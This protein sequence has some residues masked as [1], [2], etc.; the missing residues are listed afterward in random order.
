MKVIVVLFNWIS[1][2]FTVAIQIAT[3][4]ESKSQK[5]QDNLLS[6]LYRLGIIPVML[7]NKGCHIGRRLN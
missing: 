4:K 5:R 2:S 3:L 1:C 7:I 6:L